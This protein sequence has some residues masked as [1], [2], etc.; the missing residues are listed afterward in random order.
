M[1]AKKQAAAKKTGAG[2]KGGKDERPDAV[3]TN[4]P[5]N[6]EE[7]ARMRR[8][9]VLDRTEP[10][11][12]TTGQHPSRTHES[13]LVEVEEM[14]FTR[15]VDGKRY[16]PFGKD[17]P[18]DK[19]RV[20]LALAVTFNLT[21]KKVEAEETVDTPQGE[22]ISGALLPNSDPDRE[23]PTE[24]EKNEAAEEAGLTQQEQLQRRQQATDARRAAFVASGAVEGSAAE[25]K[26]LE[27]GGSK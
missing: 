10:I 20:P 27:S 21:A 4:R 14:P 12:P 13:N 22:R 17:A 25:R 7:R 18:A 9:G 19:R 3:P 1:T 6:D 8:T 24:E 2:T 26:H 11:G 16:G 23:P 5:R 15:V